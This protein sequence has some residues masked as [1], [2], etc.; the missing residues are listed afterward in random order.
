MNRRKFVFQEDA[1]DWY[2]LV[3][4]FSRVAGKIEGL[5]DLLAQQGKSKE[6]DNALEYYLD[7]KEILLHKMNTCINKSQLFKKDDDANT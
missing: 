1:I 2:M 7:E 5:H 3:K 6:I 4:Q